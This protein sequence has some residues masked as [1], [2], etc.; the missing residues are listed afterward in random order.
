MENAEVDDYESDDFEQ[1]KKDSG[2]LTEQAK[3]PEILPDEEII[4]RGIKPI[5][6][7]EVKKKA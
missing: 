5:K 2:N 7:G 3:K 6:A 1:T 4:R